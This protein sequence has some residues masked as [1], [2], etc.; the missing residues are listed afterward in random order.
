MMWKKDFKALA[1][2]FKLLL[3]M[4][5]LRYQQQIIVE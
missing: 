3:I 1:V 5:H 4:K 2:P